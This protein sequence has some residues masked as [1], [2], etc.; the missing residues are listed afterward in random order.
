[1]KAFLLITA[2]LSLVLLGGFIGLGIYRFGLLPSYSSYARKWKEFVP[3]HNVNLWS[4]VTI[5]AALLLV[6]SLLEN[7]TGSPV[8]VFGFF[9]PLYLVCVALTPEW[10]TVHKQMVLHVLFTMMCA[11]C[12]LCYVCF[13]IHL[14]WV[15]LI[16]I[17]GFAVVGLL[18]KSIGKDYIL[19]AE[20]AMFSTAYVVAF[21]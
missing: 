6:P 16:F 21:I 19:W 15:A 13:A 5:V 2:L 9:A 8:Q 4:A 12:F 3:I 18:T 20:C 11:I 14:W 10:E 17:A 1:M 7:S